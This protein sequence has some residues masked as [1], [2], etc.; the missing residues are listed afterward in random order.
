MK[1]GVKNYNCDVTYATNSELGFD[2]RDNMQ[3]LRNLWFK[4]KKTYAIVDEIDSC[5]IDEARTPLIIS[6]QSEDKAKSV[7][8]CE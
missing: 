5:L 4:E 1:K 7:Y 8:N 2:Y 3:F 6:G